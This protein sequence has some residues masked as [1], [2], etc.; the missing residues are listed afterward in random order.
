MAPPASLARDP[1]PPLPQLPG[2]GGL[3]APAPIQ[4]R[5]SGHRAARVAPGV[6]HGFSGI[7]PRSGVTA[8]RHGYQRRALAAT[9]GAG[10]ALVDAT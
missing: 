4:R 1:P 7:A 2:E 6:L 8:K 5:R 10:F 9:D 3:P